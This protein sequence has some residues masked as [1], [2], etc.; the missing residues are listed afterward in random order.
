MRTF[1]VSWTY[2]MTQQRKC[3]LYLVD[4]FTRT[5][6]C[7]NPAAVVLDAEVLDERAMRRIGR[8][9]GGIETAFVF[10]SDSPDYDVEIRFFS[11]RRE[12]GFVGHATVAAHYVRAMVDGV[13]RGKVRQ[14]SQ[15]GIVEVEISGDAPALRVSIDQTPAT[16][17]PVVP[18]E[19]LAPVLDALGIS[20]SSL[21]PACPVQ[22]LSKANSRLLIGLQSPDS[23][24]SLQPRMDR[25][26]QLT[27]HVGADGFFVFAITPGSDPMTT[28]SRMFAPVLGVPED[29][30]SGN[31]H[32]MLGV[33]LL[34]HGLLQPVHGRAS[35]VGNQGAF[36]DRPGQVEVTVSSSGKRATGVRVTGDAVIVYEAALPV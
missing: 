18:E 1:N 8:E 34:H 2:R 19:R 22:V 29:P 36:V 28:E 14:K 15:A 21:H 25:L 12:V 9:L 16:F 4:A 20:S 27:P 3:R 5:R 10:P 26:V 24:A 30:V 17:G 35:F 6:F 32:G 33:Y 23:L 11:P 13:P 31:A 7:G